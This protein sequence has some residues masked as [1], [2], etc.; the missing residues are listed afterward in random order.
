MKSKNKKRIKSI[1]ICCLLFICLFSVSVQNDTHTEPHVVDEE[2]ETPGVEAG[3]F[4]SISN[5]LLDYTDTII[6]VGVDKKENVIVA[7][8]EENG[9]LQRI[10]VPSNNPITRET[11]P[12][13]DAQKYVNATGLN[14]RTDAN[15]SADIVETL[16]AGTIVHV[17]FWI[18]Y[19]KDGELVDQWASVDTEDGQSGYV[20]A[21]YL[22]DES[23]VISMGY[24]TI[25]YY[26]PCAKCCGW[27]NGP[28]ASGVYPTEGVTIAADDSIPFGTQLTIDGHTYIVQDRGGAIKGNHI[29]IF[30]SNHQK[31]LSM[32]VHTSEVFLNTK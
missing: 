7:S 8:G 27:E 32:S 1:L 3:Y 6:Q 30:V 24:Y 25:T 23:P 17:D 11:E 14:M 28:T 29:D 15:I 12:A 31:A 2:T 26:C 18:N 19:T 5:K 10:I 20:H 13:F 9:N 22:S 4:K 21:N 16:S